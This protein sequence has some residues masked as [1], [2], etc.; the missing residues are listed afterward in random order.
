MRIVGGGRG[1]LAV[2]VATIILVLPLVARA[3]ESELVDRRAAIQ[4]NQNDP[5]ARLELGRALLGAGRAGEAITE[6]RRGIGMWS[7]R[8]GELALELHWELARAHL[9]RH[10]NG[11]AIV[12]CQIV[13]DKPGGAAFGR[14]CSAEAWLATLRASETHTEVKEARKLPNI[15]ARVD[16]SL[17]TSEGIAYA[18]ELK[19]AEAEAELEQAMKIDPDAVAAHIALGRLLVQEGKDG[20]AHLRRAV[21]LSP[22]NADALYEL[23]RTL[24][25]NQEAVNLLGRAV[26][27]RPS[28]VAAHRL[29]ATI[30]LSLGH[31]AAAKKAADTALKIDTSD[32]ASHLVMGDVALAENRLDDALREGQAALGLVANSAAARQLLADAYAK[33]GEIDLALENYQAAY[34]GDHTNPASLVNASVACLQAG[35]PTSAKAFGEKATQ[36]FA[37]WGPAWVALG[38]ALAANQDIAGARNAYERA[39]RSQGPVD[40]AGL[41]RKIATLK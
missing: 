35:R 16:Y 5:Q 26:V 27:E 36:E 39:R 12:R 22:N 7:A 9:A 13:R 37:D 40:Q 3:E 23:A 34:G 15:P 38:D 6:L 28:F 29:T 2:A 25:K 33:K 19:Y 10:E 21:E 20:S 17:H 31:M 14:A 24:P 1:I 32:I 4:K 41:Q 8:G 30:E 18:L 11:Q